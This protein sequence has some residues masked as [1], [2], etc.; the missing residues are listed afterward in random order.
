MLEVILD[1]ETKQIFDDVGGYFPEKLG[2]SF[3]GV[4]VRENRFQKGIMQS[5]FEKDLSRL[6]PLLERADVV[7]GFNIDGFD[8][9]TF[10][11]Y[12]NADISRIPTLDVMDRIKKSVGHRISL[13]AVAKETL[14]AGKN[15]DGLDA[16]RYYKSGD[17][18][19]LEKYCLRDVEVTRDIYDYGLKNGKIKFRNKW[20]RLIEAP[21]DFSFTCSKAS[22]T[23]MSLI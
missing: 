3:V 7:V 15:G 17:F 6:F 8:M 12:Y 16:I 22:G 2:I 21:V 18:A 13:D 14:G 1:V 11:P 19:A 20:N 10:I 23:Q 4:C 5:F 9:P